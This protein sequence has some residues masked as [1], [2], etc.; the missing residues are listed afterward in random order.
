M[1]A[2]TKDKI[3]KVVGAV[4]AVKQ[5]L[6]TAYE[7]GETHVMEPVVFVHSLIEGEEKV[8]ELNAIPFVQAGKQGK[9][10]LQSF[11][12]STIKDES[13]SMI[14]FAAEGLMISG[15]SLPELEEQVKE[16]GLKSN[17][18]AK[19]VI[20]IE[21]LTKERK[22]AFMLPLDK[23]NK[24]VGEPVALAGKTGDKEAMIAALA[25][26]EG[27]SALLNASKTVH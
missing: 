21:V 25:A 12:D 2:A 24:T 15:E 9:D 22:T 20:M 16:D 23:A 10:M 26:G 14:V 18:A 17:P 8:T 19:D 7:R 13:V 1:D 27:V 11:M 3:A 5:C 6:V 4:F